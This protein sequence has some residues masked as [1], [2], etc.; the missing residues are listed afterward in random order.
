MSFHKQRRGIV[1]AGLSDRAF[2]MEA[3][4]L[5][6]GFGTRLASV[7]QG[8]PKVLA[9]VGNRPFLELLLRRLAD[10]WRP[11]PRA[12]DALQSAGGSRTRMVRAFG[13]IVQRRE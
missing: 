13:Q 5:A 4:V 10:Q 2:P 7:V 11:F 6:G 9:P 12:I 1:E 8:V 3:I